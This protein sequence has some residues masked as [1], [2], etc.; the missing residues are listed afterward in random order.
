MRRLLAALCLVLLA[1]PSLACEGR[2]LDDA[3]FFASPLCLPETPARV[4]VLDSSFGL[5]IALD[6][7]LSVVGAPLDRMGDAGLKARAEEAGV[8][9]IG[10]VTEPSFETIVALQPDLILAFVGSESMASGVYPMASQ[11]A[12][13]ALFT[14]LDWQGFYRVLADISGEGDRIEAELAAYEERLADVHARMPE[15]PV[16]VLRIT[17]WDFQ[18]YLDAPVAYAPF[19]VMKRAGVVRTD[20]E[21][22]DDPDLTMKRPD[23]EELAA[24]DGDIMLYIVGGT[25]ASDTDG[26][27]EEVL[28]NPLW[29]MLP[30]VEAGRVHRVDHGTWME[31]NGL[32][33][34]HSVLDDLE[35]YVIDAP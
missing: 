18:V 5:G 35:A 3:R 19:E 26:R 14:S 24:L 28:T 31:F 1:T 27:H 25:N 11:F 34:A 12:P 9:S 8:T 29:Q 20:Y 30:A 23:W 32:G 10:F 13:T 6:A 15:T 7:G 33:S 17:S 21:T 16:S 22:T 2:S 4:V